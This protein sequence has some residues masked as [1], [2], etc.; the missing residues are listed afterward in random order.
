[1]VR[2]TLKSKLPKISH[3]HLPERPKLMAEGFLVMSQFQKAHQ[4]R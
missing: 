4:T 1:M 3:V 2:W